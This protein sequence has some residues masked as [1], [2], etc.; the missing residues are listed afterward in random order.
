M[1]IWVHIYICA[2]YSTHWWAILRNNYDLLNENGLKNLRISDFQRFSLQIRQSIQYVCEPYS[3][4]CYCLGHTVLPH[5][6]HS[7]W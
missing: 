4:M 2:A 1:V 3:Q 6:L 7:V 5:S